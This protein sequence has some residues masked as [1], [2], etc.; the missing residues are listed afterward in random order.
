MAGSSVC[1]AFIC[2]GVRPVAESAA[3][4]PKRFDS[5]PVP[6]DC[7]SSR[8]IGALMISL[9]SRRN[10]DLIAACTSAGSLPGAASPSVRW[11]GRTASPPRVTYDHNRPPTP[12]DPP[13]AD[14]F[15][16]VGGLWKLASG[17][18]ARSKYSG[19]APSY[20]ACSS[21]MTAP[22]SSRESSLDVC[23]P[24]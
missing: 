5:A 13:L 21:R 6:D 1:S 12:R 14:R 24:A 8:R 22:T 3:P 18:L 10:A 15:G 11:S 2:A 19:G 20:S 9:S 17:S 7:C 4:P 16:P 23:H